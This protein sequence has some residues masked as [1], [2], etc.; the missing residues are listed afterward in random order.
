MKTIYLDEDFICHAEYAEGRTSVETT[1]LDYVC[2][3]ALPFYR[4]VP[5]GKRWVKPNG[6]MVKGEFTQC[7]DSAEADKLQTQ[8]M[9]AEYEAALSAIETAL[10]V[11]SE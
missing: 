10:G 4:Y 1:V 9:L 2:D 11:T 6:M 5:P 8:Y 3:T 7:L